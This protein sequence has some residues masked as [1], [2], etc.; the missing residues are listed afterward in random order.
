[1]GVEET[2]AGFWGVQEV[3]S[4]KIFLH[5]DSNLPLTLASDSSAHGIG[6]VIQHERP[7]GET[8]PIA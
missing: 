8:R 7:T 3:A 4:D 5:Y 6:A 1:M 2:R